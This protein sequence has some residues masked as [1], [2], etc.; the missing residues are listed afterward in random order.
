LFT[1]AGSSRAAVDGIPENTGKPAFTGSYPP[2][3]FRQND[4]DHFVAHL[5]ES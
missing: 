3:L 1:G 2:K 5:P 4:R